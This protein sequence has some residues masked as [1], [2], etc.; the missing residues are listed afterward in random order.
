MTIQSIRI[1]PSY[2]SKYKKEYIYVKILEEELQYF[3]NNIDNL[4]KGLFKKNKVKLIKEMLKGFDNMNIN[5]DFVLDENDLLDLLNVNK[6]FDLW[7]LRYDALEGKVYPGFG[8]LY[9]IF[10]KFFNKLFICYNDESDVESVCDIEDFD[11]LNL[12]SESDSDDF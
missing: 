4:N 7:K 11:R 6:H 5:D 8:E 1:I 9:N 12:Y 3:I 2:I 10:Y